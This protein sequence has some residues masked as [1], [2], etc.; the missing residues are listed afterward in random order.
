MES[1]LSVLEY[2]VSQG[3]VLQ[4][5]SLVTLLVSAIFLSLLWRLAVPK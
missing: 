3:V 1:E 4:A 5:A 2:Q